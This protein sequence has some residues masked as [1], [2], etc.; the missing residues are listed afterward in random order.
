MNN[1]TKKSQLVF[2]PKMS[3]RLL[4]LN[5]T[6]KFCPFCGQ[7]LE[8]LCECHKNLV[9]D[10]KPYRADDGTIVP[11][12][13]VLVFDNNSTFQADYNQ[14]IEEAKAKREAEECE[15]LSIDFD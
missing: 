15:Q 8:A 7:A 11:D 14:M 13:S 2:D 10:V 5:P 6:F 3:R 4:K 12:R 9:V 1:K